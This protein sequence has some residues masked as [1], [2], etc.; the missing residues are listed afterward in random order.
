MSSTIPQPSEHEIEEML[1]AYALDALE[2]DEVV[3]VERHL[4][5]C[6]RCSAEV[7]SYHEVTGLLANSGGDAPDALWDKIADRLDESGAPGWER[8]AA[9]LDPPPVADQQSEAEEG[10]AA[11][12]LGAAPGRGDGPH[13]API[14]PLDGA[15]RRGR[16]LTRTMSVVAAAAAV[17]ALVLGVQVHH[18][19]RQVSALST[20]R[21]TVNA[22]MQAA[23]E[24]PSTQRVLLTASSASPDKSATVTLV[25]GRTDTSYLAAQ[26]LTPLG[27][28]KTYQLW[29][30]INN[31][32]ISL[33]VLGSNP[34]VRAFSFDSGVKVTAFAITAEQAG[35][36]VQSSHV[37]VVQGVVKA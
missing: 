6:V 16:L 25:L 18:L 30:V 23:L 9:R 20:V 24:N 28:G 3:S 22:A 4:R 7:A 10:R 37:P 2:P 35:G 13:G 21:P 33:G 5:T 14:I 17:L 29:G 19:D 26:G 1:G 36:V 34:T 12:L 27:A 11:G 32:R 8:L 31:Q 15:R